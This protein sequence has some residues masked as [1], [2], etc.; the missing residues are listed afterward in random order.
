MKKIQIVFLFI[1]CL[2]SFN[3][4][5]AETLIIKSVEKR[6][7]DIEKMREKL[8]KDNETN[9]KQLQAELKSLSAQI[10]SNIKSN[11]TCVQPVAMCDESTYQRI[12]GIAIS[13]G[14]TPDA[15]ELAQCRAKIDEYN[16]KL[17]EYNICFLNWQNKKIE[18]SAQ[19][20][21]KNQLQI[22]ELKAELWCIDKEGYYSSYNKNTKECEC[23]EGS[24]FINGKCKSNLENLL[25]CAKNF[26]S[27]SYSDEKG[28][29]ACED[30]SQFDWNNNGL[31]TKK[32]RSVTENKYIPIKERQDIKT[33]IIPSSEVKAPEIAKTRE[34][35]PSKSEV[36]PETPLPVSISNTPDNKIPQTTFW[37]KLKISIS[38]LKFW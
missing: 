11:F 23:V 38:K 19:I 8:D 28:A 9:Y 13:N 22:Y 24:T 34:E 35:L 32:E 2:F 10:D 1:F 3:A 17:Q 16:Q 14:L 12:R 25:F 33:A 5:H 37:K 20:E 15:I 31:C 36:I 30:G 4:V 18:D 29:C 21:Y 6:I 27:L 7:E 26:G